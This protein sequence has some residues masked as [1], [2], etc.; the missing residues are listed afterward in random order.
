MLP[1]PLALPH[2]FQLGLRVSDVFV[3]LFQMNDQRLLLGEL[4]LRL[5]DIA[6]KLSQLIH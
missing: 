5:N 4:P 1:L 2:N 3:L 6:L